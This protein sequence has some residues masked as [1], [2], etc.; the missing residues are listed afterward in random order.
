L[1]SSSNVKHSRSDSSNGES[2]AK[3]YRD[4]CSRHFRT[5]AGIAAFIARMHTPAASVDPA[6]GA[7]QAIAAK[8]ARAV[9]KTHTTA[10]HEDIAGEALVRTSAE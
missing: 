2:D 6:A 4:D 10:V 8:T 1:L 7:L 9:S 3:N 5:R